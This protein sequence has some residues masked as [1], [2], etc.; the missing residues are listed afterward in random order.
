M[1]P[2][3]AP[4]TPSPSHCWS[5]PGFTTVDKYPIRSPLAV[6]DFLS[7]RVANRNFCEIGTRNGDIMSCLSHH[8]TSVTAI[9]L[10][11]VYC[12][13]LRARGFH[14]LC[15]PFEDVAEKTPEQLAHCDV[16][17]WWPMDSEAQ[18]EV[19]LKL[20]LGAHSR[21][22]SNATVFVAHDTHWKTD[23]KTLPRLT[24]QYG[25]QISRI[26]FDEGGSL[27]GE[28]SY[29]SPFYDRP[30][31]WGVFHMAKFLA[32][33]VA[34][35]HVP[36]PL[37]RPR[38]V[39]PAHVRALPETPKPGF[40]AVTNFESGIGDCD[41]GTMGVVP[42]DDPRFGYGDIHSIESCADWCLHFCVQCRFVSFSRQ[43]NDCSWYHS[44]DLDH[45]D[46]R[47]QKSSKHHS[48]A[49]LPDT[50]SVG[51]GRH[52]RGRGR[53]RGGGQHARLTGL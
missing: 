50:S 24:R 34:S 42:L 35:S 32:G 4:W 18:N 7:E 16:Y 47:W 41:H 30:G 22:G 1:P 21:T 27:E 39:R 49:V 10:D 25:G 28:A 9:E 11:H 5:L 13:K 29:T 38:R 33:P 48:R 45:L 44:C 53:G 46:Q 6:A 15:Q 36:S 2:T 3:L 8:A 31:R 20:I 43:A 23:M 19:W 40:C 51:A 17:F 26:F 37:A 12:K 52:G 14:V